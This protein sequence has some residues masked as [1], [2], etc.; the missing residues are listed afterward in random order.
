MCERDSAPLLS[1]FNDDELDR[2]DVPGGSILDFASDEDSVGGDEDLSE[3]SRC[4]IDC[5]IKLT[6]PVGT[7]AGRSFGANVVDGIVSGMSKL[8]RLQ[9][10]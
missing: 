3:S 10:G 2:D 7:K 1:G 8:V 5:W 9:S 4:D 6:D